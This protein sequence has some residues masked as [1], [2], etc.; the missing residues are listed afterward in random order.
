MAACAESDHRHYGAATLPFLT[1]R[2]R[3]SLAY[4]KPTQSAALSLSAPL[5]SRANFTLHSQSSQFS[6]YNAIPHL[7]TRPVEV[8]QMDIDLDDVFE[9]AI[10][11]ATQRAAYLDSLTEEYRAHLARTSVDLPELDSDDEDWED[12]EAIT[13]MPSF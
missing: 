3:H 4:S 9:R 12:L 2:T 5:L 8:I 7:H 10:E 13:S 6:P 11:Y 1:R